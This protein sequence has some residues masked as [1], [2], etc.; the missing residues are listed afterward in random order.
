LVLPAA[1]Q[2]SRLRRVLKLATP[3]AILPV[4]ATVSIAVAAV[5]PPAL[6]GVVTIC[7]ALPIGSPLPDGSTLNAQQAANASIIIAVGQQIGAGVTGAVD[8]ITA[9]FTESRLANI[10]Y[11]DKDS[12]GLFQERP[13]Q[14]WGK[15]AQI[16]DP[17]YATT[18]FFGHLLALPGWQELSPAVAAQ[19]VERS[20]FPDRYQQWVQPAT[21][22]V[23]GLSGSGACTNGDG[24]SHLA[25]VLPA[26][27]S[28][29][30]GT[31]LPIVTAIQYALAQLGK[32]YVWGGI[33][34]DGYD[35]SG[36]IMQAYRAAGILLPRTTYDQ[37]YAGQ[38]VF[39]F[40]QLAPGDLLF[41]EG[42]DP[43]PAGA[44]GHVG[45]YIG[46]GTVVDAPHTGATVELTGLSAWVGQVV[47]IRRVV[48]N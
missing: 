4:L 34:P 9:A 38:P 15:P 7:G 2:H 18:Q 45:M 48:P 44:P 13:S 20:A 39:A 27:F 19:A 17:V 41:T 8:A 36:L 16:L 1:Y 40:A 30:A 47:A 22:L 24:A 3:I 37:V 46:A 28:L 26:G 42:S 12:L 23:A 11:G 29:P 35:C 33:G 14:G 21:Q 43:G 10:P 6:P 32:P 25:V 5:N 31:P